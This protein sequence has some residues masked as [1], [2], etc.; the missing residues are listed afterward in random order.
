MRVD[1]QARPQ[2]CSSRPFSVLD[3]GSQ[4]VSHVGWK[5]DHG[6]PSPT[7][8]MTGRPNNTSYGLGRRPGYQGPRRTVGNQAA[9]SEKSTT[10]GATSSKSSKR[11]WNRNW[12][13]TSRQWKDQRE[14]SL[15]VFQ[16]NICG[17]RN[18]KT[19]L[20]KVFQSHKIHVALL[21]ETT[22]QNTD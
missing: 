8:P 20:A 13:K 7:A 10:S 18:K 1:G 11:P 17:L 9:S 12:R 22:H 3:F 21:Q 2:E 19:E 5:K 4:L 14:T 6:L 15:N 16:F